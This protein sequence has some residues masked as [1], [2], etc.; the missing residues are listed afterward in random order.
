[1]TRWR[2]TFIIALAVLV[3]GCASVGPRQA[4]SA[5]H[6]PSVTPD[7]GSAKSLPALDERSTL[8]DYLKYAFLNNPGLKAAFNRWQ[9]AL[10]RIPQ[11]KSLSDPEL[12]FEYLIEQMDM[13]YQ[14][15]I[16]QMFP[17]FGKLRLRGYR[18]MA[19]AEAA[20]HEF[21]AVRLMLFDRV[22]KA[23]HEYQ[24]LSSAKAITSE[25]LQLLTDL[26]KVVRT[27]YTAGVASFSDL[28]KVQV[29]RDKLA[30]ELATLQDE[31]GSRSANLA[32]VLNLPIHDVLPW[33]KPSPPGQ[34]TI[35]E[36]VL[37]GMLKDL[38]PE[39]KA[40]DSII[41]RETYREKLARRSY[42]PDFMLGAG[43]MV[44]PGMGGGGD[45]R[46]VGI[47]VGIT[48]PVWWSKYDAEI[49][50]AKAMREAVINERKELENRLKAQLR[51]AIFEFR[52]G[53][54]RIALFRESLIPKAEQALEV[55]RQEFST[56]KADF[57][58]L[59]DAQRTLLE[60][61]LMCERAVA[62]RE[63]ALGEIG[64]C[65]GKYG[66]DLSIQLSGEKK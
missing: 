65:I 27:R 43:L 20:M 1:M 9:A 59:I 41:A 22:V 14:L 4:R 66:V 3:T 7:T 32:A 38:N 10:Q 11:A 35:K 56:S 49:R 55:A 51:T 48:L 40:K 15:S 57:M 5:M 37:Y 13:R 39:L 17:G 36:D 47:M 46:D 6:D 28:T 18:A 8:D 60:F 2:I 29:E 54:R 62:D 34:T 64:C 24:Y 25:N 26:E 63:I 61:R 19:E 58:T 16:R 21:E 30:N 42:L 12:S 53:E 31:R 23:F 33:P 44:M 52:D 45:E 50:E